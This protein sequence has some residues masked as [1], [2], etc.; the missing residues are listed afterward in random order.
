MLL[1][2]IPGEASVGCILEVE[3]FGSEPIPILALGFVDTGPIKDEAP[4][5]ESS[6]E[7]PSG[8]APSDDVP[9]TFVGLYF[10]SLVV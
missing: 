6:L 5:L 2:G 1:P 10:V 9:S 4:P 7:G 8:G 3:I